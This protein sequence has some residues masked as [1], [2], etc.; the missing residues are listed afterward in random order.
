[1]RNRLAF[2]VFAAIFSITAA[3]L[4]LTGLV[5][6]RHIS[7]RSEADYLRHYANLAG[8][9]GET[10]NQLDKTT[11]LIVINAL[12]AL[13]E[14]ERRGGLLSNE[15]LAKLRDELKMEN[16]YILDRNGVFLRSDWYITVANDPALRAYYG[17]KPPLT[18]P[19]FSYCQ[20]YRNLITGSS[21]LERTPIIPNPPGLPFERI[22]KYLMVPNHDRTRILEASVSMDFIG[23]I[24]T[25]AMKPDQNVVSIGLYTPSGDALGYVH[26]RVKTPLAK[27]RLEMAET[28]S[29]EPRSSGMDLFFYARVEPTVDECCECQLKQLTLPN[30]RYYYLLKMNVSRKALLEQL[31]RIK[32]IFL[33][34]GFAALLLS[35][36]AAVLVSRK[37]VRKLELMGEKIRQ[38]A[39]SDDLRLRVDGSGEDEV[40]VLGRQFNHMLGQL[41]SSR[42]KLAS[43]ERDRAYADLAR[44]VAHDI[45]SPLAAMG[46]L[47]KDLS[48]VSEEK[49]RIVD[50][51]AARIHGIADELLKKYRGAPVAVGAR[52][53]EPFPLAASIGSVAAE[54]AAKY[55]S[56]PAVRVLWTPPAEAGS[57]VA[58]ADRLDFERL[59]SNLVDN[60]VEALAGSG[61]VELTLAADGT[62]LRLEVRDDGKGIPAEMLEKLGRKGATFGKSGGSGLGL[63]H[64]KTCAE[65]WG[66]ALDIRS[67]PGRGTT[68]AVT[69]PRAALP[70][71]EGPV[72][73]I[74]DDPL[75]RKTWEIAAKAAGKDLSTFASADGF[76]AASDRFP[77]QTRVYLD[78]DLGGGVRGEAV[79]GDLHAKGFHDISLATGHAPEEFAGNPYIREIIGKDPP[80]A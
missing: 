39:E 31:A 25:K 35:V 79:A 49:R 71:A 46:S 61:T 52:P 21:K 74:D 17:F 7:A 47:L 72:V 77:P 53:A 9:I 20:D 28:A 5:I 22:N 69:L 24:L 4:G 30:G 63:Y 45:R 58:K 64:A 37:L 6:L 2:K 26:R 70:S 66:G 76:L 41:E 38:V 10:L 23:E 15:E 57:L 55:R 18:T 19:L 8:Q 40:G 29:L 65:A 1:M 27:Q 44:Q 16:L 56:N 43:A 12:N 68:V 54:K 73:L 42:E 48:Q 67:S 59:V 14:K 3:T 11:D 36:L 62:R 75:V 32:G 51:A 80:W 50:D 13:W 60:G 34:S 78:S 33:L